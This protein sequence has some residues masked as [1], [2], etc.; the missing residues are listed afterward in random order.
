MQE[1]IRLRPSSFSLS[2]C[3]TRPEWSH[4]NSGIGTI[5][6]TAISVKRFYWLLAVTDKQII[7]TPTIT[8]TTGLHEI[9][10]IT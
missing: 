6:K 4:I 3:V 8:E 7:I 5:K 10:R 9:R 2:L 1:A